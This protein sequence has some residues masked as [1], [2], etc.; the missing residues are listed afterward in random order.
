MKSFLNLPIQTDMPHK[1]DKR[2]N[3]LRA[4]R[5]WWLIVMKNTSDEEQKNEQKG[6]SE[7]EKRNVFQGGKSK[8]KIYVQSIPS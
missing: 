3:H 2:I 1:Y 7:E 5:R 6:E 8:N 4:W